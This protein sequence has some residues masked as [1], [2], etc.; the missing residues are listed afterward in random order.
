MTS[1]CTKC[2][3]ET[4]GDNFTVCYCQKR[5]VTVLSPFPS[6]QSLVLAVPRLTLRW[7]WHVLDLSI[8]HWDLLAWQKNSRKV[9]N[10][11][12]NNE[13]DQLTKLQIQGKG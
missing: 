4:P 5:E 10:F 13:V 7:L 12:W 3:H 6:Q 8:S 1:P 2:L 9:D 11:L